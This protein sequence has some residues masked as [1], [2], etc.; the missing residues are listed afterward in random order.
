[1]KNKF[2]DHFDLWLK[3]GQ[4]IKEELFKNLLKKENEVKNESVN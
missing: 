4:C 2:L 1:M 3:S